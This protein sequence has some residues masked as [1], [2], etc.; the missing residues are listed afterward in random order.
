MK[1][2]LQ[3]FFYTLISAILLALG[4]PNEIFIFGSPVLGL[5]SLA[6]LYLALNA[7]NS[8]K[9]A[10]FVGAFHFGLVHILSSFWL[11]NF[12]DF[13]IFTLGATALVY[14]V[15]GYIFGNLLYFPFSNLRSIC[16][17]YLYTNS[18]SDF[19]LKIFFYT[20]K[21][22]KPLV[23]RALFLIIFLLKKKHLQNPENAVFSILHILQAF[24]FL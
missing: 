9:K 23:F 7:C 19:Y 4:I 15:A 17:N 13:A 22:S 8:Y 14:I 2:F 12:K 16:T 20:A 18:M 1:G 11:A 21:N 5:F 24:R 10:G 3:I 6:P